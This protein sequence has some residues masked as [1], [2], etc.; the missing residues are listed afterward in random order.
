ME[1][2]ETRH[3]GMPVSILFLCFFDRRNAVFLRKDCTF[4]T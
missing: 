4:A 3:K 2:M 1:R